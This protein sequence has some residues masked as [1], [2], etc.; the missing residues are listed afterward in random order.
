MKKIISAIVIASQLAG[1]ATYHSK[2]LPFKAP[3]DYG[4][5]LSTSGL[6]VSAE[7]FAD[8]AKANDAFGFD[9]LASGLLPVQ[10]VMDNQS[11]Q[12]VEVIMG[13]S[14]L[15]D[16]SGRYWKV[17]ST[18]ESIDRVNKATGASAIGSGAGKG[19]LFGAAAGTLLGLA[20]GIVSGHRV[21]NAA[22]TGGVLGAAGGTIIG[23]ASST[24]DRDRVALISGDMR[25]KVLEGKVIPSLALADGFIF[26]PGEAPGARELR[27]Q[28]RFRNTGLTQTL[29]L[30]FTQSTAP[31]IIPVS[32]MPA[33]PADG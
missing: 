29:V 6:I 8:P 16:E 26:F 31:Q 23:G 1:C 10:V 24:D 2:A 32:P 17:L 21:G 30:P 33:K 27:L 22:L 3:Q 19:A 25:E 12:G 15:V 9:V 4:N 11:G 5:S 13:Q 18:T 14:F 28:I 20:L 7:S